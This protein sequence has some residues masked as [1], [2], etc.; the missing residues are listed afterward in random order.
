MQKIKQVCNRPEFVNSLSCTFEASF[1][2][3]SAIFLTGPDSLPRL[4]STAIAAKTKIYGFVDRLFPV[5]SQLTTGG[6]QLVLSDPHPALTS[7]AINQGR[8]I[9]EVNAEIALKITIDALR[10]T[11]RD[12]RRQKFMRA[13]KSRKH[14]FGKYLQLDFGKHPMSG[15]SNIELVEF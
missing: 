5:L 6:R 10:D 15:H 13:L 9:A 3:A 4:A 7:I 14:K 2:A 12:L 1:S 8:T 11:G